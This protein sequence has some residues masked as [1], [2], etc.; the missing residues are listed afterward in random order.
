MQTEYD[1][2]LTAIAERR[3]VDLLDHDEALLTILY[4]AS[5][6]PV[7]VS[8]IKALLAAQDEERTSAA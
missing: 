7:L 3:V 4:A 8:M 5:G 2:M 6:N 1:L